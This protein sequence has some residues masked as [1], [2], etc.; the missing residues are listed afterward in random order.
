M[1]KILDGR[2]QFYQWDLD[3]KL[4][5]EDA[6]INEVHFGNRTDN[7]SLVCEVYEL[8]GMRVADVPNIL[9]QENWR[10]NVYAYDINYTKY[11][12]AF[13]VVKRSKPADYVYTETEIKNYDELLER[14]EQL[15]NNGISDE[16]V[17][18]A[19]EKYLAA[20]PIEIPVESVNGQTG[21]VELT[22]ADVGALPV[23]TVIPDTTGLATETYV[24]EKIKNIN[25]PE[26]DLTGYA[27]ETYVQEQIA[28]IEVPDNSITLTSRTTVTDAAVLAQ[29]N[30]IFTNGLNPAVYIDGKPVVALKIYGTYIYL[31]VFKDHT[32][33]MD[34]MEIKYYE[35][36][37]N[38]TR[39]IISSAKT[40]KINGYAT[41]Q[42]VQEQIAAIEIPAE[43]GIKHITITDATEL[44]NLEDG[45]YIVDNEFTVNTL[46]GEI[47][48]SGA[49]SVK[50]NYLN[51][52]FIDYNAYLVYNGGNKTWDYGEYALVEDIDYLQE[53]IDTK[54][55][56]EEVD[57]AISEALANSG[58]Q[59][60]NQVTIKVGN[61]LSGLDYQNRSQVQTIVANAD[62]DAS[63]VKHIKGNPTNG[64]VLESEEYTLQELANIFDNQFKASASI[65][66]TAQKSIVDAAIQD[67]IN[68]IPSGGGSVEEVYVGTETPT[69]ENIKLWVN[70]EEESSFALKSEIPDVSSF[71]TAAQVQA[72]INTA[73]SGIKTAEEGTY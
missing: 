47:T 56:Q 1:F 28:A 7:I 71:Q 15:E 29:I 46:Q 43:A 9:L 60:E 27:T 68:N 8:D 65:L 12:A 23:D 48:F 19:V 4:I 30:S 10:I 37:A 24:D 14:V 63:Q 3:R 21:V 36:Q 38:S 18:A 40:A 6:S 66:T 32:N 39:A 11:D 20:N 13:D 57:T 59:T 70:P 52:T 50:Q 16:A 58:F 33:I 69:D 31:F 41:E 72:A 42:Y 51:Y 62:I 53:Q 45:L 54:V 25:I 17:A 26:V 64:Y 35:I 55:T 44:F 73:L 2:S 34:A 22:A 61:I 67:A 49:L 5:V